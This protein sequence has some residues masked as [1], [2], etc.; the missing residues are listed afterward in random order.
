MTDER[1]I[2]IFMLERVR[3]VLT[4]K[5]RGLSGRKQDPGLRA[6]IEVV[7]DLIEEAKNENTKQR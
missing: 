5:V 3:K 7:E 2:Q 1:K 4:D 6:A